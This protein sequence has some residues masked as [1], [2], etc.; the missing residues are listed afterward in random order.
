MKAFNSITSA[1]RLWSVVAIGVIG[2]LLL[3]TVPTVTI[4]KPLPPVENGD[5]TDVDYGPSPKKVAAI[6][7]LNSPESPRTQTILSRKDQLWRW[8]GFVIALS[9][10]HSASR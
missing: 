9:W 1:R 4:A 3:S 7:T 8:L 10:R 5:P 2:L 6:S